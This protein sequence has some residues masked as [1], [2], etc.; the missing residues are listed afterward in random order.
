VAVYK[1][2][3]KINKDI[4]N[5]VMYLSDYSQIYEKTVKNDVLN[6]TLDKNKSLI[7]SVLYN[8]NK[9]SLLNC[10]KNG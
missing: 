3:I 2:W 4:S 5:R 6:T 1:K 8:I 10:F 7:L 9:K